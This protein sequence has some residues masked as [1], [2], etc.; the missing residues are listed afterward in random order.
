MENLKDNIRPKWQMSSVILVAGVAVKAFKFW[1]TSLTTFYPSLAMKRAYTPTGI[2]DTPM[3][4]Y[5]FY[6]AIT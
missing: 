4:F 1:K 3:T 5:P 2:A 6:D